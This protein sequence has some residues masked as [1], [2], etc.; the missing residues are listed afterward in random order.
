LTFEVTLLRRSSRS[1]K[2]KLDANQNPRGNPILTSA[3]GTITRPQRSR[4]GGLVESV[5]SWLHHFSVGDVTGGVDADPK[6]DRTLGAR[7]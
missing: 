3:R 6:D 2:A 1:R 5:A 7:L 4:P